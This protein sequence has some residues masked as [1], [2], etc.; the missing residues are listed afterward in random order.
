MSDR[1]ESNLKIDSELNLSP[2]RVIDGKLDSPT[3]STMSSSTSPS[4]SFVSTRIN[5]ED[6]DNNNNLKC[7]NNPKATSTMLVGC[8][9]CLVCMMISKD[10][11]ICPKC[12]ST[13]VLLDFL[14]DEH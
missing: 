6:N 9:Y 2:P 7:S 12:K 14:Q 13:I 1:N 4:S 5:Q 3:Q 8:A 10:D 11:L